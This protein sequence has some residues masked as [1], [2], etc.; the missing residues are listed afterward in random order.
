MD[1]EYWDTGAVEDDDYSCYAAYDDVL[2]NTKV[3]SKVTEYGGIKRRVR[4]RKQSVTVPHAHLKATQYAV[5]SN[6]TPTRTPSAPIPIRQQPRTRARSPSPDATATSTS[7]PSHSSFYARL[8]GDRHA[9]VQ[10]IM[11][12]RQQQ[13][14]IDTQLSHDDTSSDEMHCHGTACTITTCAHC[15]VVARRLKSV[16]QSR[17]RRYQR[18]VEEEEA[19]R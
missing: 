5:T 10:H 7:P 14:H 6:I 11:N 16:R 19:A 9:A 15:R 17:D 12:H 13:H 18:Q 2:C 8:R 4:A 1:D 3:R